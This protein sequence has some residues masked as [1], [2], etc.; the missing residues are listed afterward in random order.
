MILEDCI[1]TKES[2]QYWTQLIAE[3]LPILQNTGNMKY[4]SLKEYLIKTPYKL[5]NCL[6]QEL[7]F[8]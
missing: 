2:N 8:E 5:Q 7:A 1:V 3:R 6:E 4:L